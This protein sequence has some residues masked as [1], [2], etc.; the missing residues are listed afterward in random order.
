M[1]IMSA[2]NMPPNRSA[3]TEDA[4]DVNDFVFAATGVRVRRVTLPNGEHWFPAVDVCGELGYT[5]S[6]KTLRDHVPESRREMLQTLTGRYGLGLPAGREWRRDLQ[7]ID[8]QGLIL[9]VNGCTKAACTPFKQ[10]VSEVI[11]TIQRDGSYHLDK[12]EIQPT[13]APAYAVPDRITDT[14]V[15]MEERSLRL[16]E[17]LAA[18]RREMNESLRGITDR[19]GDIADRLPPARRTA[20]PR[21]RVTAES[22]LRDW[23][24]HNLVITEDIWAVGAYVLPA[25]IEHGESRYPLDAIAA[26]TGLTVHRVH[27]SLRMMLKRGC[28]RQTGTLPD[29]SPVYALK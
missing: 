11:L 18:S 24:K 21:P 12:A 6:S 19:L 29:G 1:L 8:L 25:I 17:E 5:N 10:W 15:R 20:S 4:I 14:L 7:M 9:L 2:Q 22:V 16:I 23:K 26:R 27:D 13:A 3:A 28:I